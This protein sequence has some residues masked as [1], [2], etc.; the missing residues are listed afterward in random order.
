MVIN[1]VGKRFETRNFKFDDVH[2]EAARTIAEA[3]RQAG[4]ERC[5]SLS[6]S[7]L[8]LIA[9]TL[10]AAGC[11]LLLLSLSLSLPFIHT[12][13]SYMFLATALMRT[14]LQHL[15]AQKHASPPHYFCLGVM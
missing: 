12:P 13:D 4:V 11:S 8:N 2:V 14:A 9:N 1:L 15:H 6:S 5:Q 10:C 7:R 3:A